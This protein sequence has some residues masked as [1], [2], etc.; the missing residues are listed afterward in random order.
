M[1]RDYVKGVPWQMKACVTWRI[2][3]PPLTVHWYN[4]NQWV[5]IFDH[6]CVWINWW[7]GQGNYVH[8]FLFLLS[9]TLW[10]SMVMLQWA[11]LLFIDNLN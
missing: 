5:R 8:F 11:F 2:I 6:H 7:I 3:R 4:W 10:I 9:L 1:Y